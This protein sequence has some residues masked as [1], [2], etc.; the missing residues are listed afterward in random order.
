MRH[1]A[2][3][4]AP[5]RRFHSRGASAHRGT[6]ACTKHHSIHWCW[7][8]RVRP[9]TAPAQ[10]PFCLFGASG[11]S[12][13]QVNQHLTQHARSPQFSKAKLRLLGMF[14]LGMCSGRRVP[15]AAHGRSPRLTDA[16]G[17][18]RFS[19]ATR[20]LV[21][22]QPRFAVRTAETCCSFSENSSLRA[23]WAACIQ[24]ACFQTGTGPCSNPGACRAA[25]LRAHEF[26]H[27]SVLAREAVT[28]RAAA[29]GDSTG[30]GTGGHHGPRATAEQ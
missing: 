2:K 1:V 24:T 28:C 5:R 22:A 14:C 3:L 6:P 4:K 19:T 25:P 11:P 30:Q 12:P 21:L 18:V 8:G 26:P 29:G 10:E 23:G 20:P 16:A 17:Q 15:A 7:N 13:A 9:R 27:H